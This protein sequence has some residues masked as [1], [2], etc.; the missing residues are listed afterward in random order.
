MKKEILKN[1]SK[2]LIIILLILFSYYGCKST[3]E[4]DDNNN[5]TSNQVTVEG[6]VLDEVSGS[7]VANAVVIIRFDSTSIGTTTGSDGKYSKVFNISGPKEL[8]IIA[9]KEGYLPDTVIAYAVVGR[10]T[11]APTHKLEKSS[12]DQSSGNAS[13][14]YLYSLSAN[15]IGVKESG[16][17]ETAYLTFEVQDSLGRPIDLAH[18]VTVYFSI[19]SGPGGNE[20]IFPLS[21]KTD[22]KGKASVTLISGIKAGVVQIV[23]QFQQNNKTIKSQPVSISIHG[24]LPDQA[25]FSIAPDKLNFPGYNIYGLTN[26]IACYVGDKYG[27][28]VRPQTSVYFTTTGGIIQGSTLTNESGIGS[29]TLISADPKPTHPILGKGFATITAKT[30]DETNKTITSECLVLFSGLPTTMSVSPT[31]FDLPNQGSLTFN[32]MVA[33]QN[34][35]PLSSGQNI[36][37]KAEGENIKLTGDVSINIPDTQS[38]AWTQFSFTLQD[39]NDSV[40]V[41]PCLITIKTSGPNGENKITISGTTR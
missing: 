29:V 21:A 11:T 23:A 24:G 16:S 2:I 9:S 35:N 6:L 10:V 12:I 39:S 20:S 3:T 17:L 5:N 22:A 32:Y 4:P 34:N 31:T 37:V 41:A 18:S 36:T 7:P 30:I 27:N 14:I 19:G 38:P 26:S 33:D 28:P 25:H 15:N 13:S 8:K 40:K 1:F